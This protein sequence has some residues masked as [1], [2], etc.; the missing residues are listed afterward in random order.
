MVEMYHLILYKQDMSIEKDHYLRG[1][2]H[3]DR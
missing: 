3:A 2:C 1:R